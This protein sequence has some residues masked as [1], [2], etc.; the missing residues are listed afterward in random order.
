M[1]AK[2][3]DDLPASVFVVQH[4]ASHSVDFL[5]DL[6]QRDTSLVCTTAEDRR[7]FS[8]GTIYVAPAD[9]HLLIDGERMYLS[10]GP[11]ENRTR[12]AVDPLFR[13]AAL[14]HGTRVI[15]GILSGSLDDGAAGLT[16][17][18]QCGGWA[19]V[20]DPAEAGSAEM[21]ESAIASVDVDFVGTASEIGTYISDRVHNHSVAL[22]TFPGEGLDDD[23]RQN[24]EREVEILRDGSGNIPTATELGELV[25][26]SCPDC[27]GPLWQ[28][29]S[30]VRRFRCHTG[31]AFTARH[32]AAGLH[33]A[34]EESLWAALRAME[35]RCR[36]LNRL[37][38]SEKRQDG[39]AAAGFTAKAEEAKKHIGHLRAL[40]ESRA[41][42]TVTAE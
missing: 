17:V 26:L 41:P 2:L 20:Q 11:R 27:G 9:R 6:L 31:H 36:L 28:M 42:V 13:S 29:E 39:Q 12:P 24:L 21:P 33:D 25:P 7:S 22:S 16:V 3:V 32:L 19:V 23:L 1:V 14:A 4:V 8:N 38:R 40:L 5:A 37:A 35:E 18:K 10:R 34:E 30:G 15:G